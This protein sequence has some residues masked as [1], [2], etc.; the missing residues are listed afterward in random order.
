MKK[1]TQ[2]NRHLFE[3]MQQE[4]N[5]TLIKL[6]NLTDFEVLQIVK[7]WYTLGMYQDILQN[8][9]GEDLEEII[10]N[11]IEEDECNY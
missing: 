2:L 4:N 7:E 8:E 1:R 9:N 11:L 5:L 6:L 3:Q 10:N